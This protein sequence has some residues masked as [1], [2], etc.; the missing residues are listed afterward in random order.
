MTEQSKLR[1]GRLAAA[2]A[3]CASLASAQAPPAPSPEAD[4][5]EALL[6]ILSEETAVATR[7]RMNGDYVPGIVTVLHGSEL[8]ALG[9]RTVWDALSLVPGLEGVRDNEGLPSV[10]VRGMDFPFNSGNVK[11][12]ID[13]LPAARDGAGINGIVLDLPIELVERIE[14]IRGPGSVVYGDFALMGL[15][16]V[17]TKRA[18][19]SAFTRLEETGAVT[20]GVAAAGRKGQEL[21]YSV[22]AAG[23]TGGPAEVPNRRE[24]DDTRG[25]AL[26]SLQYRGWSL[27]G[28]IV[29]RDVDDPTTPRSISGSQTHWALDLRHTRKWGEDLAATAHLTRRHNRYDSGV[30]DLEGTILEGGVEVQWKGAP[31]QAWLFDASFSAAD[32]S[33]ASFLPP[34]ATT[35]TPVPGA[36]PP[37][38]APV[39]F[40]IR[41]QRLAFSSLMAQ[42]TID[43]GSRVA[44]TLGARFDRYSD[45]D[46]RLTPRASLVFRGSDRN[47]FKVQYAEGFRA[48]TFFELYS[49]G[50]RQTALD[51]EVNQTLEANVVHR[52]P[53]L[54]VRLTGYS[55]WLPE[56]IFRNGFDAQG[57][58]LFA[59]RAEGRASGAELELERE[60]G[61]RLKIAANVS[62]ARSKDS[63]NQQNELRTNAVVPELMANVALIAAPWARTRL[64]AR[65]H[66]VGERDASDMRGYEEFLFTLTQSRILPGLDLRAGARIAAAGGVGY[67]LVLVS[68]SRLGYE[69][70]KVFVELAWS[71]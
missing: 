26:G 51:F 3:L 35:A 1:H 11:I 9:V 18:G 37:P 46:Q 57:R 48:P 52:R 65:W 47:I 12:L 2:M 16:H 15:I 5:A 62:W 19:V 49:L 42:D 64:A 69:P 27:S 58:T 63:R 50:T 36:P 7:S 43:V 20:G 13:S 68:T 66:H 25:L 32:I 33:Q 71:R 21:E 14:V 23:F 34:P 54:V 31:R 41:D 39:G 59:N 30:S 6:A 8:S 45:V 24:V 56:M 29:T 55:S 38:P 44:L 67:P 70:P 4:D 17:I 61:P 22:S 40:T 60:L 53:G 28:N 10:I